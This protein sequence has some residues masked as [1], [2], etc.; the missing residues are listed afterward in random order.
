M[1]CIAVA[2][3]RSC[4]NSR[5]RES[6][7]HEQKREASETEAHWDAVQMVHPGE[8][9]PL[10]H[11]ARNGTTIRYDDNGMFGGIASHIRLQTGF[12]DPLNLSITSAP[13]ALPKAAVLTPFERQKG[14]P[15]DQEDFA[16]RNR[17]RKLL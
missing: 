5:K 12:F 14:Y 1:P 4:D 9:F 10:Y 13:Y 15:L 7:A 6:M 11:P 8:T 2:V 17:C 16:W 3:A